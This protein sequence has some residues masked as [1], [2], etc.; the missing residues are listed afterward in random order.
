MTLS[1]RLNTPL[2]TFIV[3]R[4]KSI[5]L[6]TKSWGSKIILLLNSLYLT[7]IVFMFVGFTETNTVS[8]VVNWCVDDVYTVTTLCVILPLI[9]FSNLVLKL[10]V[11]PTPRF[12]KYR[13][14]GTAVLFTPT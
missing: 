5:S 12:T 1:P 4:D 7:S 14:D 8:F 11:L 6:A 3:F 9:T 13:L 10:W 2:V